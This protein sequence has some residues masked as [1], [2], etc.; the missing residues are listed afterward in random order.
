MICDTSG[1]LSALVADQPHHE[2]CLS[3]LNE[4]EILV[5]PQLTLCEI[6]YL[7]TSRHGK[8]ASAR[9]LAEFAQP[10]YEFAELRKEDIGLALD[11]M[12]AYEDLNVG[13]TDASVVILAKRYKTNE[14]LTLDQRHFRAMRGLDGRHFRLL[15]FD[16]E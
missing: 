10:E 6:D 12:K 3:A 1:L 16:M 7:A 4:A 8:R 11:V 9:L 5:V 14:I 2:L 15:P 13:L